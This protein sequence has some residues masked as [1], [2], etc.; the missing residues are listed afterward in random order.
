MVCAR[1]EDFKAFTNVSVFK[2]NDARI[3]FIFGWILFEISLGSNS[4]FVQYTNLLIPI[5]SSSF[6]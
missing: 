6:V 4:K 5:M 1:F 2:C 3:F